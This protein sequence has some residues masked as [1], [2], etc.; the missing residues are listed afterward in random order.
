[1]RIKI[2][3]YIDAEDSLDV[4][5][6]KPDFKAEAFDFANAVEHLDRLAQATGKEIDA[7]LETLEE[8]REEVRAKL[9][10][11]EEDHA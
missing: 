8:E 1:M 6:M 10:E 7:R 9:A 2:E 5:A 11:L 3:V 4:A